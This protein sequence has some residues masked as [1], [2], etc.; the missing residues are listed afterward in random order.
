MIIY[1]SRWNVMKEKGITQY[2][3][4]KVRGQPCTDNAYEAER[5]RQHTR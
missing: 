5:K 3:L 1:D 4:K 2:A